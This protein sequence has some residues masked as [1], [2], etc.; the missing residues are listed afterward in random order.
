MIAHRKN[1][2]LSPFILILLGIPEALVLGNNS[3]QDSHVPTPVESKAQSLTNRYL[4]EGFWGTGICFLAWPITDYFFSPWMMGWRDGQ[5]SA[6]FSSTQ[7]TK[8]DWTI[9]LRTIQSAVYHSKWDEAAFI[10]VAFDALNSHEE[11]VV[12]G[13]IEPETITMFKG[14]FHECSG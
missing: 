4:N 11:H 7:V 8:S 9:I 13:K 5:K 1:C 2:V 14:G 12:N 3:I 6:V 10:V